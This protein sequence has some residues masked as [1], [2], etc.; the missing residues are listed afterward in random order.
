M[1]N[2]DKWDS[3]DLINWEDRDNLVNLDNMDKL[4]NRDLI[5]TDRWDRPDNILILMEP[6]K[7]EIKITTN[8]T[9]R[10]ASRASRECLGY[11]D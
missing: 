2:T 1:T 10:W 3:L 4:V 6:E 7:L 9:N 11:Q 8:N 5:N